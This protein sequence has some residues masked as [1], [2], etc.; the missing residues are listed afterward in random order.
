MSFEQM[1]IVRS[2]FTSW[3]SAVNVLNI[4]MEEITKGLVTITFAYLSQE[5]IYNIIVTQEINNIF[6][7]GS[8][9][10]TWND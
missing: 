8:M 10:K 3:E 5:A 2:E 4:S 1:T 6:F 9:G 7:K